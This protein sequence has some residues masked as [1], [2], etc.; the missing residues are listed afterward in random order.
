VL[1]LLMASSDPTLEEANALAGRAVSIF[2]NP[3]EPPA[4]SAAAA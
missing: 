4:K 1:D 3:D 2:T